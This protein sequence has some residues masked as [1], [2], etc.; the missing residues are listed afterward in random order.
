MNSNNNLHNKLKKKIKGRLA[1]LYLHQYS[2]ETADII[3][4]LTKNVKKVNVKNIKNRW[5][6]KDIILITYADSIKTPDVLP[7][8]SLNN[9]L[10]AHIKDLFKCIHIL[11]FFP[12]SS[13]DGFSVIDYR[14]VNLTY[15]NWDSIAA[16]GKNYDLMFDLVINHVSQKCTWFQNFLRSDSPGKDYFITLDPDTDV[17]SVVR[18]RTHNL[19]TEF[20][21]TDGL[22][23]VWTTFSRDQIDVNFKNQ[24]VLIEFISIMLFYISLGVRIIRLDA[25]AFLWKEVGTNCLHLPQTHEIVKL[26]RDITEFIDHNLLLLTETNVSQKENFSYFGNGDEAAM[27]Y[28]FALP[29][30]LVHA[31]YTGNSHHLN[32][33]VRSLIIRFQDCTFLNFTA[34]H[35]GI[36]LRPLE[37]LLP[38]NE[39]L[40]LIEAMKKNGAYISSRTDDKGNSIPYEINIT[41]YDALK[42][43]V[44]GRDRFQKKRFICSQ[45]IMLVLKGIPAFYINSLWAAENYSEG[46]DKTNQNRT[47]N[48]KK[49]DIKELDKLINSSNNHSS[50]FQELKRVILIRKVQPAF[51]PDSDQLILDSGDTFFVLIRRSLNPGQTIYSISNLKNSEQCFPVKT[52]KFHK[53]R[54]K[55]LLTDCIY[56]TS[57]NS[58]LLQPYQTL[59]LSY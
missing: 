20:Q 43:T 58:I 46:V 49:W 54:L 37:G 30:L 19:L 47:V 51:H 41:Y 16:L 23:Y 4:D 48:R 12:Y 28:Q 7:L 50:V 14:S 32:K 8:D 27:V 31:L 6:Q 18:P 36:G 3:F 42:S 11:P 1:G 55:D 24:E 59:W 57:D 56:N 45:I 53:K 9:F 39:I 34:S 13:D 52:I 33:W 21:T 17:S 5:S 15:G 40:L 29:P 26:L 2:H 25:I 22:K 35:D 38:G 44:Q 10:R